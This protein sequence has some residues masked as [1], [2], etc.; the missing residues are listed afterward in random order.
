MRGCLGI[1]SAPAP[2][3]GDLEQPAGLSP[4][5]RFPSASPVAQLKATSAEAWVSLG[6]GG[7]RMRGFY[8]CHQDAGLCSSSPQ[9]HYQCGNS[10]R[11]FP[12]PPRCRG[13]HVTQKDPYLLEVTRVHPRAQ[14]PG[15]FPAFI[16]KGP[17]STAWASRGGGTCSRNTSGDP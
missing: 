3:P 17:F 6:T 8:R 4:V 7:G 2:L 13:S 5:T 12:I 1:R 16:F 10:V 15:I 14:C 9:R 11:H